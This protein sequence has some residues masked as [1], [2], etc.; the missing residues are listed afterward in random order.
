MIKKVR[1]NIYKLFVL[2][3]VS[4][5]GLFSCE[6]DPSFLGTNIIPGEDMVDVMTIDTFT[7]ISYTSFYDT[8][9]AT[10]N[11]ALLFGIY[12]V[13]FQAGIAK[14]ETLTLFQTFLKSVSPC[15]YT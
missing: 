12:N 14:G 11:D 8:I 3:F 15:S 9:N 2:S 10:V 1:S 4:I 6:N 5:F 13:G 7:V